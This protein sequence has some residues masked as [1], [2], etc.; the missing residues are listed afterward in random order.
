M[1]APQVLS[2]APAGG[3]RFPHA[4]DELAGSAAGVGAQREPDE[5]CCMPALKVARE[6]ERRLRA[7][8]TTDT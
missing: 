1:S 4:E 2:S 6:M 3:A 5:L 7:L 8:G